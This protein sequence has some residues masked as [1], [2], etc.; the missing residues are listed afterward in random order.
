MPVFQA[1]NRLPGQCC[2]VGNARYL[3]WSLLTWAVLYCRE[4]PLLKL[5]NAYLGSAVLYVITV[6]QAGHCLL[7]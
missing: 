1:G 7:G 5:V 6:I 2:I 4:C 3:S